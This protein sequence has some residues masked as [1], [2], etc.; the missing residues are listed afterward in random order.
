RIAE[1]MRLDPI[2]TVNGQ[3]VTFSAGV[4]RWRG[5]PIDIPLHCADEALYDAKRSGR[6]QVKRAALSQ[7][8]VYV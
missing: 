7:D 5:G 6:D 4:C 2:G 1:R 8:D 3:A